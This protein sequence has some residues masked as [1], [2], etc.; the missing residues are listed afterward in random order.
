MLF[1]VDQ[2]LNFKEGLGLHPFGRIPCNGEYMTLKQE[3]S[4]QPEV[5][6]KVI[7]IVHTGFAG[8]EHAAEIYVEI[9]D[10]V[11]IESSHL[12]KFSKEEL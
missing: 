10:D 3:A 9:P 5:L 4:E 1:R 2:N 12:S 7:D 6:Y 11:T 8:Y